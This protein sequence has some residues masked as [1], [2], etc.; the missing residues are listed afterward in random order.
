MIIYCTRF[1]PFLMFPSYYMV[2]G[3]ATL[4]LY[5]SF[6]DQNSTQYCFQATNESQDNC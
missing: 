1:V 6:F 3:S 4:I 5:F 2:A